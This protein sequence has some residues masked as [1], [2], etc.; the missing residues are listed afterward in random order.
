MAA[1]DEVVALALPDGVAAQ[2]P[3]V[4]IEGRKLIATGDP[5][6]NGGWIPFANPQQSPHR[7]GDPM[8]RRLSDR[9]C[10]SIPSTAPPR[11][12][13]TRRKWKVTAGG[14]EGRRSHTRLGPAAVIKLNG[15]SGVEKRQQTSKLQLSPKR[16]PAAR[17]KK[18]FSSK[19][20]A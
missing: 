8:G 4:D 1:A 18:S 2:V 12:P 17:R 10:S 9:R 3:R 13:P 15:Q 20:S 14:Q 16:R 19:S 5:K 7:P 11:P 6:T